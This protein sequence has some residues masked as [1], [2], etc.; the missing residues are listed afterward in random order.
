[1]KA[2]DALVIGGG[3]AG[4]AA[5]IRA[6]QLGCSVCLVDR[7]K[8]GEFKIGESLPPAATRL[9][10]DLGASAACQPGIATPSF[11]NQS[12][13]GGP[14]LRD[15]DFIRDPAGHGWHLD[16]SRFDATLR[17]IASQKGVRVYRASVSSASRTS[18]DAWRVA[19][20]DETIEAR[21]VIDC[22]G[23]ASSF[24][25]SQSVPRKSF[26]RL[27]AIFSQFD[28]ANEDSR[29]LVESASC[30]WWY[31]SLLPGGRRVVVFHTDAGI[32][33][34]RIARS[35]EG[36]HALL[37]STLHVCDQ[38]TGQ[39]RR[40][41]VVSAATARLA[42]FHGPGWFAA[43]DAA[44][45]FD[46]LSSQ[47]IYTALYSGMKAAEAVANLLQAAEYSELLDRVFDAYLEHRRIYYGD[48]RRWPE[49]PF[50]RVR[51]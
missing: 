14:E 13:W 31:T 24:V 27:I 5:A 12:A 50:W 30:G 16:R 4:A 22:A 17:E 3:P 40:P 7:S 18:A 15:T 23:R 44:M 33:A 42:R 28:S 21:W 26:D 46:P 43:G 11:G 35:P 51:Q 49:S 36:F 34:S 32:E 38:V 6:A 37:T 2:F 1:M 9:L 47:G 20:G 19:V 45:S 39:G 29:T 10:H 48:E 41:A 25:R 8:P